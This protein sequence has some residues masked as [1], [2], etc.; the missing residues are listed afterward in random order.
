MGVFPTS[1]ALLG[2]AQN[3]LSQLFIRLRINDGGKG[4]RIQ[5]FGEPLGFYRVTV[6]NHVETVA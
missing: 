2:E 6:Q 1:W 3:Q 4:F 5:A